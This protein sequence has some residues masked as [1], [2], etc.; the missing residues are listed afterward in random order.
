[1]QE[2][3]SAICAMLN[4]NGGK[5]MI[6]I[7]TDSCVPV[8]GTA[9]SKTP[10]VIRILEQSII[11]IIGSQQTVSKINF[12]KKM[13]DKDY[14]E[15]IV[16]SVQ[17][18][19][20][21][22]TM[23]YNLCLPGETQVVQVSSMELPNAIIDRKII[24]DP[25]PL[26]SH[27]KLFRKA[28]ICG[29]QTESKVIQ[30]K[31]LKA[32]PS[33]RTKLAHRMIGKSNKFSCYVSAFANHRGGHIYYG[34]SDDGVVKG[35]F[36]PNE[37]DKDEIIQKVEKAIKK[38]IW[39]ERISEPKRGEH[40]EIF[41]EPV[42]DKYS[43]PVP[44][45]F[46]VVIF[47]VSCLGG[48]F[49]EEP[50]CYE[51]IEGKVSK[52]S[53][54]AWKKRI[55]GPDQIESIPQEV[56]TSLAWISKTTKKLCIQVFCDLTLCLNNGDLE[57]FEKAKEQ[58]AIKHP[59]IVELQLVV[60]LKEILACSRKHDFDEAI[61]LLQKYNN[62]QANVSERRIFEVLGL[63]VQ[64]AYN[65]AKG[66]EGIRDLLVS[67]V[68]K[69]QWL[70]PGLVTTLVYLFAGTM[71]DSFD[72]TSLRPPIELANEALQHLQQVSLDNSYVHADFQHR[73]HITR[74]AFYLGCNLSGNSI[75]QRVDDKCVD[76]AYSSI[77]AIE[78]FAS[79]NSTLTHYRAV[80]LKLVKSIY[81]F[82]CSQNQ[83][84]EREHFMQDA[85]D[86]C[87]DAEVLAEKWN[88]HE[89]VSW[90]RSL[91]SLLKQ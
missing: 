74:A 64:A 72:N 59:D 3:K 19:E 51:M 46:V 10:L 16:V 61:S 44:S 14:E 38:M 11:S 13:G 22:V 33:K 37:K 28:E 57:G 90:S 66:D 84:K 55:L 23:N 48:V 52:M 31:H 26:G 82:R 36:I 43:T 47:I 18:A 53:F 32:D 15:S 68:A 78:E 4:S 7:D 25:S 5:V 76:Q 80:Q 91:K 63:Y 21:L 54:A 45:T 24:E 17:K 86:S 8:E 73:A 77:R 1:M 40:W 71:A 87:N 89:M 81:Y 56:A 30:F 35:E 70:M 27:W 41:F 67:A 65:R 58:F 9:F 39:P 79:D 34:I 29:L 62:L 60:L 83:P 12:S 42:L 69:S 75:A 20:A 88:F 49:T 6:H 2:I 85:L 50:E